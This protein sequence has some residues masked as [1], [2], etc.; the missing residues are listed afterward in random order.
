MGRVE[1]K[2]NGTR[3]PQQKPKSRNL[4]IKAKEDAMNQLVQTSLIHSGAAHEM[5]G[6]I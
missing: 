5:R 3:P 6:E 2:C 1:R 4:R